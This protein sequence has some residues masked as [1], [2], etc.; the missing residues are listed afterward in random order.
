MIEALASSKSGFSRRAVIGKSQALP[1]FF[2]LRA[3]ITLTV[4]APHRFDCANPVLNWLDEFFGWVRVVGLV[5][6][7][8]L[9]VIYGLA[10]GHWGYAIFGALISIF[11]AFVVKA[12]FWGK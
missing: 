11:G 7:G 1:P 5:V 2:A 12:I 3:R 9:L 10:S 6:A 4:E 8:P